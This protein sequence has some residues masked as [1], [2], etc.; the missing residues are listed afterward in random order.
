M[1]LRLLKTRFQVSMERVFLN[2]NQGPRET[3]VY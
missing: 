2:S 1:L 3:N